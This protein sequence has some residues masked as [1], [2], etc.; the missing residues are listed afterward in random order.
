MQTQNVYLDLNAGQF[1]SNCGD[2]AFVI[3]VP[4]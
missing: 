4:V 2:G 3:N 1:V